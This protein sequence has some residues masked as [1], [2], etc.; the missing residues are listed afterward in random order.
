M[1]TLQSKLGGEKSHKIVDHQLW[2]GRELRD[3]LFQ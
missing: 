3:G 2:L 1:E